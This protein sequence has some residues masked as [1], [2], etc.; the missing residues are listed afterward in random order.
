MF[1]PGG[2]KMKRL[3]FHA[4]LCPAKPG[5]K[6]FYSGMAGEQ[7]VGEKKRFIS[8]MISIP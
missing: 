8:C 5:V 7:V 6:E 3:Y 2:I 4:D 1:S